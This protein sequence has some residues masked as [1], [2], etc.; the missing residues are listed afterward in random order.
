[1]LKAPGCTKMRGSAAGTHL[2]R[3]GELFDQ[4]GEAEASQRLAAVNFL[5]FDPLLDAAAI[6]ST[7]RRLANHEF[8]VRRGSGAAALR[9]SKAVSLSSIESG[10]LEPTTIRYVN[11]ILSN[12]GQLARAAQALPA[13]AGETGLVGQNVDVTQFYNQTFSDPVETAAQ[14]H[15]RCLQ[16]GVESSPF[17]NEISRFRHWVRCVDEGITYLIGSFD[18]VEAS[19][20][21]LSILSDRPLG[22]EADATALGELIQRDRA[23]DRHVILVPHSQGNLIT[24]L[25]LLQPLPGNLDPSLGVCFAAVP[26][27]AP[28]AGNWQLPSNRLAPVQVSRDIILRTPSSHFPAIDTDSSIKAANDIAT[29]IA[30][31]GASGGDGASVGLSIYWGVKLHGLL[32]SYYPAPQSR[33]AIGNGL[34]AM[35]RDCAAESV[36]V[37]PEA[38]TLAPGEALQLTATVHNQAGN[39]LPGRKIVWTSASPGVAEVDSG[40]VVHAIANGTT[41]ISA[42]VGPIT[43]T[44]SV[45]VGTGGDPD[46]NDW[47]R[48]RPTVQT[49]LTGPT[50]ESG[51]WTGLPLGTPMQRTQY[52]WDVTATSNSGGAIT[53]VWVDLLR[54]NP[55][56]VNLII[57]DLTFKCDLRTPT[58]PFVQGHIDNNPSTYPK[59]SSFTGQYQGGAH[60]SNGW[61]TLS[62]LQP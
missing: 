25:A 59:C 14:R 23:A 48:F 39:P 1:M 5:A 18:L 51:D 54:A 49:T 47:D 21:Y 12:Q 34:M 30:N 53:L 22:A 44:A 24:Q 28:T 17:L 3:V 8:L 57:F 41:T 43:G 45:T 6:R 20:Q 42:R 15:A 10:E 13:I 46:P 7:S 27:A 35:Y 31:E 33:Q 38:G 55:T 2:D 16:D 37:T 50:Q 60:D 9:R 52:S 62:T 61:F 11:G 36:S 40:G 56:I 4:V 32:E 29:A 26:L 19:R 58:N